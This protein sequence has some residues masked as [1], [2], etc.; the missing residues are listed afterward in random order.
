MNVQNYTIN[1]ARSIIRHA[2]S[3]EK[4]APFL[5]HQNGNV[6]TSAAFALTHKFG[7]QDAPVIEARTIPA[8]ERQLPMTQD[9][10]AEAPM[11]MGQPSTLDPEIE[12]LALK[13]EVTAEF[14][15][16][17]LQ[18]KGEMGAVKRSLASRKSAATRA[19]LSDTKGVP[20][21]AKAA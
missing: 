20:R 21:K 17:L 15:L 4:V 14:V 13:Y 3:T 19:K 8:S 12:A 18:E 11:V 9:A 5:A 2:S 1:Q 16:T 10:P 7:R 6:R